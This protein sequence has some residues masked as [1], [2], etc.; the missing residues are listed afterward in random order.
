MGYKFS[1]LPLRVQKLVLDVSAPKT[2]RQIGQVA[3]SPVKVKGVQ[4]KSERDFYV[5]YLLPRE[6]SG[7]FYR[8]QY[9]SLALPIAHRCVY[10]PDFIAGTADNETCIFE[11]KAP[12]RFKEKGILK[13]KFAAQTYPEYQFY[14]AE[15]KAGKWIV[16]RIPHDSSIK[17]RTFE[18][19]IDDD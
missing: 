16:K 7:E 5:S 18:G 8:V 9:E 3:Q 4:N 2:P 14:H 10:N 1:E 12:H 17:A 15:K 13:L 6:Q 11:V 19:I